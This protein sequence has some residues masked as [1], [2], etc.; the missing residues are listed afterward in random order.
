L[1]DLPSVAR[2]KAKYSAEAQ[3][4]GLKIIDAYDDRLIVR[5]D[6]RPLSGYLAVSIAAIEQ[7]VVRSLPFEEAAMRLQR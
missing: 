4:H 5:L 3:E 6:N 7:C 1:D 2:L